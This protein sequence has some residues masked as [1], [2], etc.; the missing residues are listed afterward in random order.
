MTVGESTGR[1]VYA[2]AGRAPRPPLRRSAAPLPAPPPAGRARGVEVGADALEVAR[3]AAPAQVLDPAEQG[4]IDPEGGEVLE[5]HPVVPARCSVAASLAAPRT[6]TSQSAGSARDVLEVAPP[7]Q[8][9]GGRLGPPARQAREPVGAVAD[10]GQ[11]VGDGRRAARRTWRR[12]PPR[13]SRGPCAGRAGRCAVPR[14]HCPRSLSGVQMTTCSTRRR[15]RR[16]PP[17][18]PGR[19]PPRTSTIGHTTTPSATSA[20]SRGQNWDQ[21]VGVDARHPSC[22]R[23]TGRCGTTRSRGRWPPRRGWRPRSSSCSTEPTH[24]PDGGHLLP[25]ALRC[26][27]A[28]KKWRN[29][30]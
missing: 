2:A 1:K 7:G 28:P 19:R 24:A 6:V 22:S 17:R 8:H 5:E 9:R 4:A 15:R 20:S 30:S 3:R 27:G 12:R 11:V 10:E 29:S 21:Q 18:W 25:A 14:T 13:R 26:G 23:A 16:R